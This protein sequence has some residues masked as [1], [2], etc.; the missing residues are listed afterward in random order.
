[1]SKTVI[2]SDTAC[3]LPRVL[4]DQHGIQIVPL[5]LRFGEE[6]YL[7]TDVTLDEFWDRA[8]QAPPYPQTSQPSIGMFEEAFAPLVD[9]G[10]HV[11]CLTVTSKHSGTFNSACAASQR[12]PGRVTVF[13]TL[14]LSLGQ[15]YQAIRAGQASTRG[16]SVQEI[17]A[18][19]EDIRARTHL[20][21]GLD[22]IEYLRRGGRADS[23]M[24]VLE[25]VVRVLSIK[26]ILQVV[27]GELTL[28]GAARSPQ[29]ARRRIEEEIVMRGPAEMLVVLH[30]R[31]PE[32]A[33]D[34]AQVL[35]DRLDFS[36]DQ[37]LIGEAGPALS[38]HGRPCVIAAA[39]VEPST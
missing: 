7:E 14:S 39:I 4:R 6:Q 28:L 2:V 8:R 12:F 3:D 31:L 23:V 27:E 32:E 5:V 26:P 15:G 21:I 30:V 18:L 20:F 25:R 10:N 24:P 38:C 1:M 9:Q 29:R 36:L 35:G 22:S 37:V 11:L 19:L 13:D 17:V 34:F 16:Q 33:S